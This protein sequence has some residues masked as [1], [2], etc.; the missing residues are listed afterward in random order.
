MSQICSSLA[1]YE[2]K[3]ERNLGPKLEHTSTTTTTISTSTNANIINL[4]TINKFNN[5][6]INQKKD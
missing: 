4:M 3:P 6:D 5:V 1:H 2:Q